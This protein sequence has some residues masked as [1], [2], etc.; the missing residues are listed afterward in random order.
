MVTTL[1]KHCFVQKPFTFPQ[2]VPRQGARG[3]FSQLPPSTASAGSR[4]RGLTRTLALA[5]T[6][7][8][9]PG[10]PPTAPASFSRGACTVPRH[11]TPR[12]EPCNLGLRGGRTAPP[13]EDNTSSPV[14]ALP[15]ESFLLVDV[16]EATGDERNLLCRAPLPPSTPRRCSLSSLLNFRTRGRRHL[17][18]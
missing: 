8:Q 10:L 7:G 9:A 12:P 17:T 6:E 14:P 4:V 16:H 18:V 11:F 1:L 2:G 13:P 15:A 3:L 5:P